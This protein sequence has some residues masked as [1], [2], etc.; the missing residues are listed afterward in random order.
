MRVA[1]YQ[2]KGANMLLCG[3]SLCLAMF[4][5]LFQPAKNLFQLV[6]ES[7]EDFCVLY[8]E[9]VQ[10]IHHCAVHCRCSDHLPGSFDLHYA[11]IHQREDHQW[12]NALQHSTTQ[13]HG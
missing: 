9:A 10:E 13:R 5:S 8:L 12:I 1:G 4:P 2:S 6:C 7:H 11:W 3:L